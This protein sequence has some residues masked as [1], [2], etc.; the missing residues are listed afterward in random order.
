MLKQN[1]GCK[2]TLFHTVFS[3]SLRPFPDD[4]LLVHKSV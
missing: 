1:S 2:K 3:T 4:T